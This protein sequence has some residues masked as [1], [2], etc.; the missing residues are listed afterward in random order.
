MATYKVKATYSIDVE[1]EIDAKDEEEANLKLAGMDISDILDYGVIT[2]TN[3]EET[4][5]EIY[6]ADYKVR[7][8]DISYDVNFFDIED[9]VKEKYSLEYGDLGYD[10]AAEEE[11]RK[12]K[13]S[14]PKEMIVEVRSCEPD[15]LEDYA[16]DE[17]SDS[18]GWLVNYASIEIL[19]TK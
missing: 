17:V 3:L 9:T 16:I 15:D 19:E 6:S 5:A 18:T 10:E 12:V 7:V 8:Y 2:D 4:S 11:I 13:E 14:L 1:I